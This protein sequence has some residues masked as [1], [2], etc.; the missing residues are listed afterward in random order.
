ML[1]R[2]IA[3]IDNPDGVVKILGHLN[4]RGGQAA[5]S[6]ARPPPKF[7]RVPNY[8]DFEMECDPIPH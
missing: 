3:F 6:P 4:L 5:F 7:D 8:Q 1:A 2:M